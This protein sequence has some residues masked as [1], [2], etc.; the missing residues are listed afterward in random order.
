MLCGALSCSVL[1]GSV[2]CCSVVLC[3][4]LWCFVVLCSVSE[5]L[6]RALGGSSRSPV[7]LF[8]ER[9]EV[10]RAAF[11]DLELP[12]ASRESSEAARGTFGGSS[13]S[14]RELF[15]ERSEVR[16]RSKSSP[17]SFRKPTDT[18]LSNM[19]AH[20][21]CTRFA[22]IVIRHWLTTGLSRR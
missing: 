1:L 19:R 6:Q 5:A 10:P 22:T 13:T 15:K 17:R 12:D 9:A 2:L 3:S 4:A 7:R 21:F 14:V 18:T 11:E 20:R 8:E 16:R